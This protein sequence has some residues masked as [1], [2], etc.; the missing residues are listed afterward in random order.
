MIKHAILEI[1][2]FKQVERADLPPADGYALVVDG[3]IKHR[4]DDEFAARSA[5]KSLLKFLRERPNSP[6]VS[7]SFTRSSSMP[8]ARVGHS[9]PRST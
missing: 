7:S 8:P 2:D 3:H 6:P 5:G 1:S 9:V 4:Y